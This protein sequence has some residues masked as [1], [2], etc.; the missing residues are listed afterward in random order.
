MCC[1]RGL[2]GV[3]LNCSAN[4][5]HVVI[6]MI[7][8]EVSDAFTKIH[9]VS[10]CAAARHQPVERMQRIEFRFGY[11]QHS[12]ASNGATDF[13]RGFAD[14][15]SANCTAAASTNTSSANRTAAACASSL[16]LAGIGPTSNGGSAS[17][18]LRERHH[19]CDQS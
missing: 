10:C 14:S 8:K 13:D 4:I 2:G 7:K 12:S 16:L 1:L 6:G 9:T 11:Q 18:I 15:G 5:P 17:G 3:G 19:V